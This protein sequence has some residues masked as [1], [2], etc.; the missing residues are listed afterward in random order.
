MGVKVSYRAAMQEAREQALRIEKA[1]L[2]RLVKVAEGFVTD[3][4]LKANVD[5][6]VFPSRSSGG[7]P[8]IYQDQTANL[9]NSIGYVIYKDGIAVKEN[10]EGLSGEG[11]A[12]AK[13]ALATIR[14]KNGY[15]LIGIAGMNYAS[16]VE[17]QGYNV[18]TSQ[19]LVLFA[20]LRKQLKQLEKKTGAE[21]SLLVGR[22]ISL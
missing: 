16:Y 4:R 21:L 22:G 8:G 12:S 13:A 10:F 15:V 2:D 19:S 17:S 11:A 6:S 20:D 18:I 1:L 7:R 14:K 5:S 9:K 3:A